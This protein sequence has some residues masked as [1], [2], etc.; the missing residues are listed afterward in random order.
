MSEGSP[1]ADFDVAIAGVSFVGLALAKALSHASAGELRILLFDGR[2][3]TASKPSGDDDARAFAIAAAS[4][5]LL[6]NLGVWRALEDAAQP[7]LRIELTDTALNAGV[8]QTALAWDNVLHDGAPASFIVPAARLMSGLQKAVGKDTAVT[9]AYAHGLAD[10]KVSAGRCALTF[11]NGR[12]AS[13]RLLVAA[14]G[15]NSNVRQQFGVQVVRWDT[16][17]KGIVTTIEHTKPHNGT[18]IQH[19]LPGGPFACLPRVGTQSCITWSE[20][21]AEA[22]RILALD[23]R[24]FHDALDQRL[25]GRL[26]TFSVV[27]PR[28]SWPLTMHLARS[29]VADRVVLAGDAARSVHPLAGQGLNLGFRDIGALVDVVIEGAR[30]GLDFGKLDVLQRYQR[31]RRADSALNAWGYDSLNKLFSN[32]VALLRSFREAGLATVDRLEG[33]KAMFVREAAG[34]TGEVPNLMRPP[35]ASAA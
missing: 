35:T 33:V 27:G 3:D 28:Q 13:C 24:A 19:F 26:G 32:D 2:A 21:A 11:D 29:Y 1:N 18:A 30:I 34:Q 22:D 31:W 5:N 23:D 25:A 6:E 7:V 15:Q 10:A 12:Q 14:D 17:Q 9:V 16:D 20:G 8:R 4:R